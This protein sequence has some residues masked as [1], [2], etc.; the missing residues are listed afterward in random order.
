MKHYLVTGA[1]S[2]IGFAI[3][4]ILLSLNFQVTGI[5][6]SKP[7]INHPYFNW[8]AV[9]LADSK[10][11][12]QF[13]KNTIAKQDFDGL[14]YAAGVGH[15]AFL[16]QL[17]QKYLQT[18][19]QVNCLSAMQLTKAMLASM[20][21]KQQGQFI[22]I[23]S[24]A[25]L[26]GAKQSTL[27]SA[28]KFALRGFVQSLA[29][30]VRASYIKVTLINLGLVAT[31]FHE[32][33]HFKPSPEKGCTIDLTLIAQHIKTLVNEDAA[34]YVTELNIQPYKNVIVKN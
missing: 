13:A 9:D 32:Q 15:F 11:V 27:Y 19:M 29:E 12:E 24:E 1:S 28:T 6:R 26:N 17:N 3:C 2:G 10:A 16:E 30:E 4:E 7:V 5:S 23:G 14:I 20:K 33:C 25:A 18:D 31:N 34:G 22:F 21:K 8:Y